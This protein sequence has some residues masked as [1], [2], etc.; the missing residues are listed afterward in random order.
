VPGPTLLSETPQSDDTFLAGA[1]EMG[2][3]VRSIDWEKTPLG[4][5]TEWPQ[6]LRTTM[7]IC[8]NSKFPIAVYWGPEYLMLYNQSLVPMVG[9]KKHPGALGQ[10]ANVVL[11]EIWDIIEPLLRHVRT[12]GE[13]TWSEDLMLP[14]ARTGKPEESYF[15]FT[16][17]PIRDEAGQVG[18]VFCAVV[19]TTA[20]VIEGRRLR[21][22]NALAEGAQSATASTACAH[23][24]TEITRASKDVPFA[25]LYLLDE[26]G[27]AVLSGAANIVAGSALAPTILRPGDAS[28]WSCGIEGEGQRVLSLPEAPG[29][30]RGAIILPIE[31]SS[32]G[33]RFGFIVAGLSTMLSDSE[34]YALF[35][36]LL[37]SSI[38]RAVGSA[39]SLEEERRRA[40]ELA[41]IDRAKT[42]FFSNVS[43]EFRTPLTLI[44]GATEEAIAA[45]TRALEGPE[46][47]RV[48]RNALRLLKL[49]NTLLDF[50]RIEAGRVK[51]RFQPTDLSLF[52]A[53]LASAFRSLVERAGSD[54]HGGLPAAGRARLCRS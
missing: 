35:H 25:L 5:L 50:S 29:G 7:S 1:G 19:E 30:A 38:S 24:A 52:T 47:D 15:T 22:L 41:S 2:V 34:S 28:P 23:A 12:T 26:S 45:S 43:H 8:L 32:G 11:A 3:L 44:L 37:S 20:K 40:E 54:G 46:L 4:P 27:G 31:H 6:S 16:Y 49:V 21:L 39:S 33:R 51:A 17:S 14:L 48:H 18:G 10:K 53:D 9:P 13:A 36:A 42:T